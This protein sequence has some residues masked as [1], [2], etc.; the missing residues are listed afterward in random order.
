MK[1][2]LLIALVMIVPY[3]CHAQRIKV[4]QGN[5]INSFQLSYVDSIIHDGNG[6]V[7]VYYNDKLSEFAISKVDSLSINPDKIECHNIITEQLNG[8]DEGIFCKSN[9]EDD[10][11]IVSR[12]DTINEEEEREIICINS[13]ANEDPDKAIYFL[14]DKEGNLQEI[15]TLGYQFIAQMYSEYFIFLVYKNGQ[16]I[17]CFDVPCEIVNDNT[18]PLTSGS[19][20]RSPFFNSKGKI[21]LPKIKDFAGKAGGILKSTGDAIN[22]VVNLGEGKYGD[23]LM[24]L[25]VGGIIGLTDL[26]LAAEIIA[27]KGIKGLLKHF[28][29][30]DK[31][32][33]I[34]N[35]AIEITSIKRTSETTITVE[36]TISNI[37]SIPSKRMVASEYYPYIQEI[38][39]TVYW[40]IAE[41]KSGQPGLYLHDN[42]TGII[43]ISNGNF[44]YTFYLQR[45]PGQVLYFRPFLVPE[46]TLPSEGDLMPNPYTCIRYGERKEFV[47]VDV[48][49]S[50]F[51]QTTC[52]KGN[53]TYK[54]QFTIDGSIP[55]L[56]Q[57][58]SGWGIDVK[59]KSGSYE[60]RYNAKET[61]A[62]YPPLE[63]TFTCDITIEDEDITDYGNERIAEITITPYVSFWNSMP[64]LTFLDEKSYTITITDDLCPDANHPHM[65]DLGLPSGTKWACCNVGA[66]APE[67]YGGYYAWGETHTKSVY[68]RD[69]YQYYNS[70]L[71]Y[72]DCYI[73]I[74]DDIAGTGYDAAT[75][76]WG[77]PWRM[78]SQTRIKELLNNTFSEWT[79][80]NGVKGCKFT[81]SNGGTIFLPAAGFVRDGEL[82]V[83]GSDGHYWS[84]T[85]N[86]SDSAYG[87]YFEFGPA[88]WYYGDRVCG[89]SVRP[90]R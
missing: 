18:K 22:T 11:Y 28:Y 33:L 77:S 25:V 64:P 84:S 46:V 47:D 90:V 57:E 63:K 79:T 27:E 31:S 38:S 50:N 75:A 72:P 41:G 35:A 70:S 30:Q 26:P 62:Y 19:K 24:D 36:G 69:T 89:L 74:G 71:Y 14:F 40:G 58:L 67:E 43:P 29:E 81:G 51:K 61:E 88:Y 80:V 23:I 45:N 85:P 44:T 52:S 76:N 48:N 9:N 32:R 65:I 21:S 12:T 59:T 1:K 66:H 16:Y 53:G 10:F 68:S 39:N 49:L 34:G 54:A 37:S 15:N 2:I 7:K 17:G 55:G 73:N 6:L 82:Y 20:R 3:V 86:F 13:F 60:Q 56:F 87:L 8:W 78:P 42:C 5:N 83:V 4:Y